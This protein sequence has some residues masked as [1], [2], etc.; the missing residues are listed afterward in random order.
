MRDEGGCGL[1]AAI[2]LVFLGTL[3]ALWLA[4]APAKEDTNKGTEQ[5]RCARDC[6]GRMR[7][8]DEGW[9]KCECHPP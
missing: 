2:A 6:N 3:L 7:S 9:N 8:Y 4:S 5:E 1:F